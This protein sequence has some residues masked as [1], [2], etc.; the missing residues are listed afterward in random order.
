MLTCL[1][2]SSNMN[3]LL[4]DQERGGEA[5]PGW[6]QPLR[7]QPGPQRAA[8]GAVILL[9]V[10]A[11]PIRH[12]TAFQVQSNQLCLRDSRLQRTCTTVIIR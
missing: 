3:F 8:P 6:R 9:F 11:A 12:V 5:K 1:V 10:D 7:L 4:A 2:I